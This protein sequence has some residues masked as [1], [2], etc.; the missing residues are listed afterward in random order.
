MSTLINVNLLSA[1]AGSF[2]ATQFVTKWTVVL[3]AMLVAVV[4]LH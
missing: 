1:S 4:A 3:S 2:V